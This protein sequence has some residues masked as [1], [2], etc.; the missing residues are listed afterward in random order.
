M[1]PAISIIVPVHNLEAYLRKCLDSILSQTFADFEVI[2]VNDGSTDKSGEICNAYAK[3]DARMKVIHQENGGVSSTRNAG[4]A[5]AEGDFIG[6]IDGDDYLIRIC[7]RSYI[8]PV[9]GPIVV[10]L[11]ANWVGKLTVSL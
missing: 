6:F 9:L 10:S 3:Q 8:K 1:N 11:F 2:V 5:Q 7:I 4:I